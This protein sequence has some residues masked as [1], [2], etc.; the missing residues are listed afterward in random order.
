MEPVE[1]MSLR[2]ERTTGLSRISVY[3]YSQPLAATLEG[4]EQ[5]YIQATNLEI[6]KRESLESTGASVKLSGT[7]WEIGGWALVSTRRCWPRHKALGRCCVRR[8][9]AIKPTSR[10]W[11]QFSGRLCSRILEQLEILARL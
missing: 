8:G 2:H 9:P 7:R 1:V 4:V 3:S 11:R 10:S 5:S 6:L